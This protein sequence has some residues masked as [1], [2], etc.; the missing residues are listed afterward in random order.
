MT[1]EQVGSL[2]RAKFDRRQNCQTLKLSRHAVSLY[3]QLLN[4]C[5]GT[6]RAAHSVSVV[7]PSC[8]FVCFFFVVVF[9]CP[10]VPKS[11]LLLSYQWTMLTVKVSTFLLPNV[12]LSETCGKNAE[13]A[14]TSHMFQLVGFCNAMSHTPKLH[15]PHIK[16]VTNKAGVW[17]VRVCNFSILACIV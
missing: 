5:Q 7:Q 10:G 3:T 13:S 12:I 16:P 9:F 8:F 2:F 11:W 14:I 17:C 4:K 15:M 1:T 6:L